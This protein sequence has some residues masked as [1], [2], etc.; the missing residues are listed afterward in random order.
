MYFQVLRNF[1]R[2]EK[3]AVNKVVVGTLCTTCNYG[4]SLQVPRHNLR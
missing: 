2:H 1:V 4:K 3:W